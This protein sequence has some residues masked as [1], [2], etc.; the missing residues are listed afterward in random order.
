[1]WW[2]VHT[3]WATDLVEVSHLVH[4]PPLLPPKLGSHVP[5]RGLLKL[6]R[7]PLVS[8]FLSS[9]QKYIVFINFFLFLKK[10]KF[11]FFCESLECHHQV[12]S[13]SYCI[14]EAVG[15]KVHKIVPELELLLLSPLGSQ[16][17]QAPAF[18]QLLR[19][20]RPGVPGRA[21]RLRPGHW[22]LQLRHR[23]R[24]VTMGMVTMGVAFC[25]CSPQCTSGSGCQAGPL[26]RGRELMWER[27]VS[28]SCYCNRKVNI[29][30]VNI[31]RTPW[32]IFYPLKRRYKN[33]CQVL[34]R[35]VPTAVIASG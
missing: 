31:K 35:N 6:R 34:G 32:R 33:V 29:T 4:L 20:R 19:L 28:G 7:K 10:K 14:I 3:P 11:H 17:L 16:H 18:A 25:A 23:R 27:S 24:R 13:V 12:I 22:W 21:L 2:L 5:A 1:M 26:A 15:C 30:F 8:Q 9:F